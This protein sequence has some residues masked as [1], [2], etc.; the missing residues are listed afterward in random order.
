MANGKLFFK[1][2]KKK[3]EAILLIFL[4]LKQSFSFNSLLLVLFLY[5]NYKF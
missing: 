3:K 5:N 4:N 2:I 1:K